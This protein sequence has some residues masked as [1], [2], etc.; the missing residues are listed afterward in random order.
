LKTL[1]K[2]DEDVTAFAASE[3]KKLLDKN[4]ATAF[5]SM[6]QKLKNKIMS[7]FEAKLNKFS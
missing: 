4:A 5:N 6:R 1:Q 7:D 2:V 3:K